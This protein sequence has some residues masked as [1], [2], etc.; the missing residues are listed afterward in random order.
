M[1]NKAYILFISLLAV[2]LALVLLSRHSVNQMESTMLGID[3][4]IHNLEDY[5]LASFDGSNQ[6][7]KVIVSDICQPFINDT[8]LVI[9]LPIG[10]CRACFSS[11]IYSLQ[12]MDFPNNRITVISEREDYEV[13]TEC[14]ARS[15]EY[16]V[17]DQPVEMISNIILFRLYQGFLPITMLFSLGR[18]NILPLYLSDEERLFQ[19]ISGTD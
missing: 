6:K 5:I 19:I 16:V 3:K 8:S 11:L 14:I 18:E 9:Y 2:T 15:I 4:E 1:S 7:D 12:D 10:L 17:T 13:K